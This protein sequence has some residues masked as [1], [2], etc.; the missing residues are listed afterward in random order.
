MDEL[1]IKRVFAANLKLIMDKNGLNASG[2]ARKT[3]VTSRMIGYILKLERSPT[4]DIVRKLS[5][6]LRV[7]TKPT[8]TTQLCL[9]MLILL[10]ILNNCSFIY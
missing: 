8:K 1:E 7:A 2:V 5:S 6:G 10:L 4:I 9:L 3:G